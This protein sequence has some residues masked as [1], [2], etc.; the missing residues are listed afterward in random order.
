MGQEMTEAKQQTSKTAQEAGQAIEEG[1]TEAG[2]EVREAGSEMGQEMTEAGQEPY[3]TTQEAGQAIE[4]GMTEAGQEVREAGSEMGQEMN[5]DRP[6]RTPHHPGSRKR[7]NPAEIRKM[8]DSVNNTDMTTM[9]TDNMGNTTRRSTSADNNTIVD[10]AA[11]NTD[12]RTLV[13]AVETAELE[14][15]LASDGEFTVFAPTEAAFGKLPSGTVE[16]LSKEILP[17]AYLP[18]HRF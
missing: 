4:E 17:R 2:Q 13:N 6:G 7:R 5:E 15:V 14:D 16:G 8:S 18:R 1:V 10:V 9:D 11:A 3:E 12:F